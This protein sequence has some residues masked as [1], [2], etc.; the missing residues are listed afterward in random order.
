MLRFLKALCWLFIATAP[1]C[2][3]HNNLNDKI[4]P[5]DTIVKSSAVIKPDYSKYYTTKDSLLIVT[6]NDDSL[7]YSK[8]EFNQ[9]I[10][11]HPELLNIDYVTNPD[12][13]YYSSSNKEGF[14]SEAGQ[15]TYY[16]LYAYF[17][18]QQQGVEKY[19][20]RRKKLIDIY[21]NI[22]ALY[23]HIQDGGTYFGHQQYRIL[24][25]AE[26]SLHTFIDH[27]SSKSKSYNITKE[28]K[29]YLGLLRQIIDDESSLNYDSKGKDFAEE[30]RELNHIVDNLDQLITDIFYLKK[31]QAFQF[32]KYEYY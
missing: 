14:S 12:L 30:T 11:Q 6:E 21:A 27:E 23:R 15:D 25:Y 29:L 19:A 24:A 2:S 17:L 9:L 8:E 4:A 10:D 5:D 7:E 1:G 13:M 26:F 16:M 18:K 28:K 20:V 22:N 3:N 32:D 31:A